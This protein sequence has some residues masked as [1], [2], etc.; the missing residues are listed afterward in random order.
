MSEDSIRELAELLKELSAKLDTRCGELHSRIND[1][2][3]QIAKGAIQ[4]EV[5]TARLDDHRGRLEIHCVPPC[6]PLQ[7]LRGWLWGLLAG[8]VGALA[9]ALWALVSG[10]NG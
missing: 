1:V 6:R 5:A 8:T 7:E 3:G 9:T 2:L 4:V 10:K